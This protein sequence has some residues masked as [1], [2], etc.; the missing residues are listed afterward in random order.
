MKISGFILF[1]IYVCMF[2]FTE[3][4]SLTY[5]CNVRYWDIV[6]NSPDGGKTGVF[7]V[8]DFL[9]LIMYNWSMK[10]WL[11]L[12]TNMI[13]YCR[14]KGTNFKVIKETDDQVEISFSRPWDPSLQG[15]LVSLNI[16][17][18]FSFLNILYGVKWECPY[19]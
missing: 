11:S 19:C 13:D 17:K 9:Y 7:E 2:F 16:D 3:L 1:S 4:V 5:E 12:S 8:Y 6:W 15:K 18:R 14:I 10:L